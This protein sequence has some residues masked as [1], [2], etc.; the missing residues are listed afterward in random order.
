MAVSIGSGAELQ[1][2]SSHAASSCEISTPESSAS[3]EDSDNCCETEQAI[4]EESTTKLA[5]YEKLYLKEKRKAE[6]Y[7]KLLRNST[8][9]LKNVKKCSVENDL[10]FVNKIF[11]NDQIISLQRKQ[12]GKTNMFVKW[13]NVTI[14]KALKLK[15]SCG[16]SGYEELLKQGYPL[17]SVRTLQRRS[18]NLKFDSGILHEVFEFLRIK[19]ESFESHEKDCVLI[20]DEM[21]ITSGNVYDCSL[22]KYFGNVTL[23]E[24]SGMATH[25][26]VFMLG[27]VIT[28]WKQVVAYYYTSDSVNGAVFHD[29]IE[30]IFQKAEELQL[31]ILKCNI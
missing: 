10:S 29:I 13:S 16:G 30:C 12:Q 7:K 22:S 15:F 24:H 1:P 31:N 21:A 3:S 9:R 18:Q 25:V 28:R 14:T 2:S 8:K 26:L 4:H 17:P 6:S 27:G 20:L 5:R 19:V 23:P 11:N